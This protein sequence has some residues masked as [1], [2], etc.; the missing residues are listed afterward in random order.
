MKIKK[1]GSPA[2]TIELPSAVQL[3]SPPLTGKYRIT[4]PSPEGNDVFTNPYQTE[5]IKYSTG[6][7]WVAR[8]IFKNCS[9]TYD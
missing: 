1:S 2:V 9:D 4:C 5:D 7:Y 6:D 3:S 8:S